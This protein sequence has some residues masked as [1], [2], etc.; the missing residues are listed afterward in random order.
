VIFNRQACIFCTY[1][2]KINRL[3]LFMI[4]Y[5]EWTVRLNF[6]D[7][8]WR[9]KRFWHIRRN[10]VLLISLTYIGI[11][12][13]LVF[14]LIILLAFFYTAGVNDTGCMV[15]DEQTIPGVIESGDQ[16]KANYWKW[17]ANYWK[18]RW[19]LLWRSKGKKSN[20]F[21]IG[22]TK[23][24]NVSSVWSILSIFLSYGMESTNGIK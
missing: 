3:W 1:V 16:C 22:T 19:N 20:I 17:K 9:W 2:S 5:D 23:E 21:I 24:I 4:R 18:R 12:L 15:L 14:Y 13:V 11:W 7:Y 10:E 8:W 6:V